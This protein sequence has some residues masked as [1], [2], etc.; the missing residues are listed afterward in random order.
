MS[1]GVDGRTAVRKSL[2]T[3]VCGDELA[4]ARQAPSEWTITES[5]ANSFGEGKY[6]RNS[7]GGES[8]N[9]RSD[10]VGEAAERPAWSPSAHACTGAPWL[11]SSPEC[12]DLDLRVERQMAALCSMWVIP[13]TNIRLT[14]EMSLNR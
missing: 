6:P 1:Q 2:P 5:D 11:N 13:H 4:R 14:V 8:S 9:W 10:S 7:E 12:L 3:R